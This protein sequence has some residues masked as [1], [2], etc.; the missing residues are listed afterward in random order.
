[1]QRGIVLVGCAPLVVYGEATEAAP[2]GAAFRFTD[3]LGAALIGGA[4]AGNVSAALVRVWQ[5]SG[6]LG[7]VM[8]WERTYQQGLDLST[9]LF[10]TLQVDARWPSDGEGYN[11]RE[12]VDPANFVSGT[13]R[14]G[15][16]YR[17]EVALTIVA[18]SALVTGPRRGT[19][20]V[21]VFG[22]VNQG[23]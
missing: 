4:A 7:E 18:G 12:L 16:R 13:T 20:Y 1:M 14:G 3:D 10:N 5:E 15:H 17:Y 21:D 6:S 11:W 22:V 2:I 23:P 8:E 9:V 19:A